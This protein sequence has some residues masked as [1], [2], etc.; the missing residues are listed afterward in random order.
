MF[1]VFFVVYIILRLLEFQGFLSFCFV[2]EIDFDSGFAFG[3]TD[4][5]WVE[6]SFL[7]TSW[8][9]AWVFVWLDFLFNAVF[10]F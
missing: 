2:D 8:L 4:V 10:F 1:T 6:L 5:W 9:L 7:V 3:V